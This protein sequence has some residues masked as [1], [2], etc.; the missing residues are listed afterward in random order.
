MSTDKTMKDYVNGGCLSADDSK[1]FVEDWMRSAGEPC[2]V[3]RAAYKSICTL[4]GDKREM[5]GSRK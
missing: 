2:T 3:C 4:Y 1:R 5:R